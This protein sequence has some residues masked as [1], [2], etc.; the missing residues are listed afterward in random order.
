LLFILASAF[1]AIALTGL[2]YEYY[3]GEWAH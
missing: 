2:I 3:R 1:G